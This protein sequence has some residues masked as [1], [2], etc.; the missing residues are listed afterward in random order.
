VLSGRMDDLSCRCI[1]LQW[2]V[3]CAPGALQC[4]AEAALHF[5]RQ[6]HGYRKGLIRVL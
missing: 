6:V 5:D 3:A 1:V 4:T 2:L